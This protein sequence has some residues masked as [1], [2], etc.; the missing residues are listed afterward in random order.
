MEDSRMY[1]APV[2]P[3]EHSFNSTL[4]R[5]ESMPSVLVPINGQPIPVRREPSPNG[6]PQ[7]LQGPRTAPWSGVN[8][9][10]LGPSG[11]VNEVLQH[12]QDLMRPRDHRPAP[13]PT[14]SKFN[15]NSVYPGPS[16]TTPKFAQPLGYPAQPPGPRPQQFPGPPMGNPYNVQNVPMRARGPPYQHSPMDARNSGHMMAAPPPG[17]R[18]P[19][20]MIGVPQLDARG[21]LAPPAAAAAARSAYSSNAPERSPSPGNRPGYPQGPRQIAS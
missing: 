12:N 6:A 19:R 5:D 4:F 7:Q 21:N 3:P 10:P 8:P 16:P 13:S 20:R 1:N 18:V 2:V 11:R 17:N 15:S 9:I 14:T